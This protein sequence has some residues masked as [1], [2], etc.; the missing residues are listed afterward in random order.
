MSSEWILSIAYAFIIGTMGEV[1]KALVNAK[2]GDKG[3]RGVYYVTYKSHGLFVGALGALPLHEAGVV[4]PHDYFGGTSLA[5]YVMW[6]ATFGGLA[7][8]FYTL[9]VGLAKSWF[10]HKQAKIEGGE[11]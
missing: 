2:P 9:T 6:G 11:S 10:K 7:M 3:W 4:I 5:S 1:T 8:I